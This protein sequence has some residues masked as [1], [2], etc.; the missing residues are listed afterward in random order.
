MK[1]ILAIGIVAMLVLGVG[2]VAAIIGN[3][4]INP[5][6]ATSIEKGG[7]SSEVIKVSDGLPKP[8][9]KPDVPR[10]V[11]EEILNKA[12]IDGY[13]AKLLWINTSDD[14]Y[15]ALVKLSNENN[16]EDIKYVEVFR[17]NDATDVK[18]IEPMLVNKS[19]SNEILVQKLNTVGEEKD[20]KAICA[21]IYKSRESEEY[22][23]RL[24]TRDIHVTD[25][26]QSIEGK[27]IFGITLWKLTAS[28]SFTYE[29][30]VEML[31]VVDHSSEYHN[32]ALG[33]QCDSFSSEATIPHSCLGKV[34][35]DA[36]F[37][38]PLG[39]SVSAWA[40]V[41]VNCYGGVAGNAGTT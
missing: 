21:E 5:S 35:A 33:W 12:Q 18:E 4:E 37:S 14:G 11:E 34:D 39:Q 19:S 15:D 20:Q 22:L 3:N 30:G 27:N 24:R 40:W 13:S 31:S 16:K 38:G 36:D 7:I 23:L 29:Y 41:T 9:E 10:Q 1:K 6:V 28:G 2:L 8:I 26:S 25:A 32:S 17:E